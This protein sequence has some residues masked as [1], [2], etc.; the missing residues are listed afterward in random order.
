[1]VALR[2]QNCKWRKTKQKQLQRK[3]SL[4]WQNK[5][6]LWDNKPTQN[7]DSRISFQET[8][9]RDAHSW[10]SWLFVIHHHRTISWNASFS[11]VPCYHRAHWCS[12]S[13]PPPLIGCLLYT[14]VKLWPHCHVQSCSVVCSCYVWFTTTQ[15]ET[16]TSD[17]AD[18][19][20]TCVMSSNRKSI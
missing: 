2:A 14:A 6:L 18:T 19:H 11:R 13:P 16:Q 3:C 7:C 4:V 12:C 8:L 20:W 5:M 9:K 17:T 1:M 15:Q 10:D